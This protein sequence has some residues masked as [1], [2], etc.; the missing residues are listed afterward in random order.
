MAGVGVAG[1]AQPAAA[2][3]EP[4]AESQAGAEAS[5][6][7]DGAAAGAPG[8]PGAA[9]ATPTPSADGQAV[10]DV[11]WARFRE[12]QTAHTRLNRE[13]ARAR[14]EWNQR[15]QAFQQQVEQARTQNGQ[16]AQDYELLRQLLMQHPDL[17]EQLYQRVGGAGLPGTPSARPAAA[18]GDGYTRL[19]PDQEKLL[20]QVAEYTQSQSHLSQQAQQRQEREQTDRELTTVVTNLLQQR[21]WDGKWGDAAKAHIFRRAAQMGDAQMEDVPY[22]FAEWFKTQSELV[23]GEVNRVLK[24]KVADTALPPAT[25]AGVAAPVRPGVNLGQNDEQ[26]AQH[27]EGILRRMGWT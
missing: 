16:V 14:E 1:E 21:G 9:Q 18:A 8:Q 26:T 15:E 3:A 20:R 19:H 11:P 24:G 13:Y 2:A 7:G 5:V 4:A 22:L 27:L 23:N 17:A 25:P 10:P 12:V 6:Q